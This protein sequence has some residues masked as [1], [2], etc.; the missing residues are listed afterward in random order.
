MSFLIRKPQKVLRRALRRLPILPM[1][2]RLSM[3]RWLRGR[4]EFGQ[5]RD[6]DVAVVSF[7]KAG[8]TWVR[9]MVSRFLHQRY[10]LSDYQLL[11]FDNLHKIGHPLAPETW[12]IEPSEAPSPAAWNMLM[13]AA[14]QKGQFMRLVFNEMTAVHK[15]VRRMEV[16]QREEELMR[17]YFGGREDDY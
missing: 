15:H 7:G 2:R 3:E 14:N 12:C 13:M 9:V 6:A 10:G 11:I 1:E 4:E 8:R 5:L 17:G 16:F